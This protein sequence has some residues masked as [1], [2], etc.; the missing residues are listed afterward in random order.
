[1]PRV[2]VVTGASRGVGLMLADHFFQ[3]GD[4]VVGTGRSDASDY[5]G[6]QFFQMDVG[7]PED[8]LRLRA[9]LQGKFG[10]VDVLINN[11]G[12]GPV[13]FAALMGEEAIEEAVRTNLLGT[14]YVSRELIRLMNGGRII[15]IGSIHTVLKPVGAAIYTAT[16]AAA[17]AFAETLARE[18][19]PLGITVNTVGLSPYPS[20]MFDGLPSKRQR[21][22]VD[23]LPLGR[24]ATPADVCNVV[25]F[26]ASD[27]SGFITGQTLY[28]GGV[29]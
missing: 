9:F 6:W 20:A 25:D 10:H 19:A 24:M 7:N 17:K 5:T 26:F 11:A 28:L 2:I 4:H 15:N 12:V 21:S 23:D 3:L 27:A 18:V 13:G 8:A 29:S 14:V 16:K 22:F 1:M